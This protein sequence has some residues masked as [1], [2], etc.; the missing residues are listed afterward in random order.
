LILA[1]LAMLVVTSVI[2]PNRYRRKIEAIVADLTGRPLVIEGDLRITWFPWLGVRTA[3][4]E[5]WRFELPVKALQA[6]NANGTLRFDQVQL[7][8]SH[9]SDVRLRFESPDPHR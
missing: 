5:A 1:A 4:L 2:D 3:P 8:D 6:I 9:M 7:A